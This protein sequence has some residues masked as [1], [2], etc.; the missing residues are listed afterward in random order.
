MKILTI[1]DSCI[2]I[3]HYGH[4]DRLCPE[5]PTPIFIIDYTEEA[6]GCAHNVQR[7]LEA[8]G[9]QSDII[10]PPPLP[11]KT[12]YID[13][14]SNQM[15]LRV[16][17]NDYSPSKYVFD[18]DVLDMY[19][20][21]VI[22]DYGKGFL[23]ESAIEAI[24]SHHPLTFVDTKLPLGSWLDGAAF[25]K[26]NKLE[27]ERSKHSTASIKDVDDKLIVTLGGEGCRY[28]NVVIPPPREVMMID[29]AGAG[30]A[31]MAGFATG[32]LTYKDVYFAIDQA[33]K[34][35]GVVVQTRGVTVKGNLLCNV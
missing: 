28:K 33:Q 9:A 5:A 11:K 32:Y 20:G 22:A 10:A 31:F 30:D 17:E 16:D 8:L 4:C 12:R 24:T 15:L 25:I 2:D 18:E 3:F 6:L 19:D 7:D 23:D 35:A 29:P 14:K 21:I 34:C 13:D 27:Y 1:G 26:I